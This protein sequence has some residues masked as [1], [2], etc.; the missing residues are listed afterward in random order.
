MSSMVATDLGTVESVIVDCAATL[1]RLAE[2]RLP[3]ALD[4]RLLWLSE[5]KELLTETE[6]RELLAL[7]ELTDEK[8]VEKLQ[9]Q[10]A[11]Q[12]I[13]QVF[14]KLARPPL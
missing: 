12:R 9:S 1:R 8:T 2:Y 6:R 4:Q 7:V 11:L 3:A 10:A 13:G 5:N 14:P